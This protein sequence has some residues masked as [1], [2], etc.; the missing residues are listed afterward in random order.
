[1][2]G[3]TGVV[4]PGGSARQLKWRAQAWRREAVPLARH[5]AAH[6]I[7][8]GPENRRLH[9]AGP[10]M[11]CIDGASGLVA[12]GCLEDARCGS[13][14]RGVEEELQGDLGAAE[15]IEV[16]KAGGG[17]VEWPILAIVR[18]GGGGRRGYERLWGGSVA[19]ADG[20]AMDREVGV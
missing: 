11:D 4:E 6:C 17:E 20:R 15:R 1:M 18:A 5:G 13:R 19:R 2:P 14:R 10:R 12:Q 7:R 9:G 3:L 8:Y 16:R